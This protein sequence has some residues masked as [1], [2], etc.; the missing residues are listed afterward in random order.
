METHP[1]PNKSETLRVPPND[2]PVR[3]QSNSLDPPKASKTGSDDG[4]ATPGYCCYR[5]HASWARRRA[6]GNGKDLGQVVTNTAIP[7]ECQPLP[8]LIKR[9]VP[10]GLLGV[11]FRLFLSTF[12]TC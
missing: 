10:T 5:H 8:P 9:A 12:I 6:L 3:P 7:P 1:H 2:G 4:R 11:P